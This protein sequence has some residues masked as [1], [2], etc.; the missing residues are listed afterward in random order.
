VAVAAAAVH[1]ETTIGDLIDHSHC[2][3]LVAMDER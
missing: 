3:V 2:Y 1:L